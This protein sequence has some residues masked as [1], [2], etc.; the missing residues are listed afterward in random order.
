VETVTKE[1]ALTPNMPVLVGE[2]CY[3]GILDG[4]R[5]ETARFTFWASILSGAAGHTYGADGIWQVNTAEA[6]FGPSPH[7][8]S[9]GG[10]PW[11]EAAH[12]PG[13]RQLGLAK[14]FLL[15]YPWWR[16]EPHPEWVDP[17]WSKQDYQKPYA[18]GIP[19]ELRIIFLPT[20]W[21]QSTVRSLESGVHY[22]AFF[23]DPRNG[24]ESPIGDVEVAS[25]GS[26]KAPITPTLEQWILVLEKKG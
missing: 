26:W 16:L 19:G 17:H 12:L 3:E 25:D 4:N 5:Q 15:R 10:P 7:G 18:A 13:S 23:F 20:L 2:V 21:E 11:D 8:R 24:K 1:V 6:P 14:Q 22:R 9:W